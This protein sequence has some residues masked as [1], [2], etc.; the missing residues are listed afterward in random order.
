MVQIGND[1]D[2]LLADEFH[3]EYYAQI[4]RILKKEYAEHEIY[5]PMED[6]FNALRYTAYADVKAVLLGQDPYHGPGQAQGLCFSVRPGV[7]L[8]PSLQNIFTEL[9][10]DMGLPAPHSGS[11]IPWAKEGVLLLNT[12]LTVRR[13]QPNSHSKIGWTRFTDAIIQKLNAHERPIVF[14]LWGGNARSKKKFITNPNH[15]VLETVHPSPLSVYQ[16][17]FGC[18]HFSQCNE[19]LMQHGIA[20]IDWT[21]P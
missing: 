14:L 18:R 20:P 15:L 4:R 7:P 13:G 1:W 9:E 19:F 6:I 21:L 8:P 17:F 3:S 11:L 5:P 12:T 2:A 10:N 16:G